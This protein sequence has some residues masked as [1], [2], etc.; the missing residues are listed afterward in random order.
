M[1]DAE[2][3]AQLEA[4]LAEAKAKIVEMETK[5][6][7]FVEELEKKEKTVSHAESKFNEMAQETGD[8][9]KA[10]AAA[11]TDALEAVKAEK[12][13]SKMLREAQDAL[14]EMKSTLGPK[15]E[16]KKNRESQKAKTAEEIEAGLSDAENATLDEAWKVAAEATK[17]RVKTDPDFKKKFLLKAQTAT[18]VAV[19]SDLSDWR[20]SPAGKPSESRDDGLDELFKLKKQRAESYPDG[21]T[22]GQRGG[23][24][25]PAVSTRPPQKVVKKDWGIAE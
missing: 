24:T 25:K 20:S 19:E 6:A 18:R 10:V 22:S 4:D 13:A 8:N 12:E 9:R 2:Q 11:A 17:A 14:A 15:E 7:G 5:I 23:R 1:T 21:H 16:D 3:Q